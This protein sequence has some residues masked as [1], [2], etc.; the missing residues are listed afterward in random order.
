V[1]AGGHGRGA[2]PQNEAGRGAASGIP[3]V[4]TGD[5]PEPHLP[6]SAGGQGIGALDPVPLGGAGGEELLRVEDAEIPPEVR[7]TMRSLRD[8][9]RG[10]SLSS[11]RVFISMKSAL[12]LCRIKPALRSSPWKLH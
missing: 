11:M 7:N 2:I 9:M 5:R 12:Y 6:G 10:L 3:W 4:D 8:A 1:A